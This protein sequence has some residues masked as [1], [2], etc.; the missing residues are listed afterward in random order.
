[1]GLRF[2]REMLDIYF[3]KSP[4]RFRD[5]ELYGKQN[6]F[7][8]TKHGLGYPLGRVLSRVEITITGLGSAVEAQLQTLMAIENSECIVELMAPDALALPADE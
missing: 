6:F 2:V 3:C 5:E 1:M 8:T 7:L 4:M